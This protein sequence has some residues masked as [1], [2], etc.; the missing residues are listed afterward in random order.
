MLGWNGS[1]WFAVL[2]GAA[3]KSA[4]AVVLA[5]AAAF[6]LR[7]RSAAARHMV[8]TAAVAALL[9]LPIL[10]V[11][12][13]ALPV[14]APNALLAEASAAVF[15]TTVVAHDAP[16]AV[17]RG[18]TPVA[19]AVGKPARRFDW[20]TGMVWLWAAGF[21]LALARLLGACFWALRIRRAAQPF[22]DPNW[23][24]PWPANWGCPPVR[25]L[26]TLAAV[27]P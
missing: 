26:E 25:V 16:A 12:L 1:T 13:P 17:G 27:G 14:L 9:A 10:S 22:R 11:C 20:R 5:W 21:A 18:A 8:W 23:S 2:A 24:T 7:G 3:L 6:L 15:Q 4:V 19:R